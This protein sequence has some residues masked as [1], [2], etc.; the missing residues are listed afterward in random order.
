MALTMVGTLSYGQT[1]VAI[2]MTDKLGDQPF[3]YNSSI[4]MGDD[5]YIQVSR[6]QY[7]VS[8]I[9]LIHDGGQVTPATDLH[10]LFSPSRDSIL[11]LGIFTI[12]DLEKI[13]F[14]IGVDQAHN[15]LDPATYPTEH[16]LAPKNPSMH[17]GWSAGYRFVAFEG[18][19][20]NNG[21]NFPDNYQIHTVGDE[22]YRTVTLNVDEVMDADTMIIPITADY[23]HLLDGINVL[24]GLISHT[25]DGASKTIVNN[26]RDYVF[27]GAQTSSAV[28]LK[29]IGTIDLG[30]NP[31]ID[32]VTMTYD[33]P[34]INNLTLII[35]DLCGRVVSK[36][37]MVESTGSATIYFNLVP[38]LYLFTMQDGNRLITVNK[39]LVE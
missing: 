8:E 30:P 26:M 19:S 39:V 11:D 23:K 18:Y 17:W 4:E 20:G 16:P 14:S 31:A 9:K 34:G 5:Y 13:E 7:Y 38:G 6:L 33:F 29:D 2:H 25:I 36:R 28:E 37:E 35:S 12:E 22:N 10:F 3:F 15:H 1:T 32:H 27:T 21:V 24:G